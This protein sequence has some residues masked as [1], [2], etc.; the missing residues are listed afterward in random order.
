MPDYI[1]REMLESILDSIDIINE[2]FYFVSSAKTFVSNTDGVLLLDAISMRLQVIG[3][4]VK[5]IDKRNSDLLSRYPAIE[6]NKIMKLR[7]II[8]HHYESMDHEII[9]DI[10]KNHLQ[11]LRNTLEEILKNL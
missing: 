3:E 11:K 7:D 9:Y 10:C 5:Q 4:T 2:R 1:V 6:W 8:S